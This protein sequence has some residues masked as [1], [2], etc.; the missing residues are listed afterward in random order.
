MCHGHPRK[1]EVLSR[2]V[3]VSCL[4]LTGVGL[5]GYW[6]RSHWLGFGLVSP[7]EIEWTH[8]YPQALSWALQVEKCVNPPLYVSLEEGI[9]SGRILHPWRCSTISNTTHARTWGSLFCQNY[10]SPNP[11]GQK[12]GERDKSSWQGPF[13]TS[14]GKCFDSSSKRWKGDQSQAL[15]AYKLA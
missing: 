15:N 5:V 10:L 7:R 9:P 8:W 6:N 12:S 2:A 3:Q 11:P 14:A 1:N 13:L 4:R